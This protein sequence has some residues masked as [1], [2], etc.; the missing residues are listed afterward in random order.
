VPFLTNLLEQAHTIFIDTAPVIY[1][2][3]KKEPYWSLCNLFFDQIDNGQLLGMI[4]PITIAESFYY[5]YKKE[6][7]TLL[8]AFEQRLLNNSRIKV[9]PLTAVIAQR[10]AKLRAEYN[11]GLADALQIA[12]A[13]ETNCDLFLT[14]DQQ[15]QR[16]TGLS[17]LQIVILESL[18]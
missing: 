11:L 13:I 8:R 10:S 1:F 2:V 18:R 12:T 16:V 4:S 6:Q 5:P 17:G 14:N 15:L 9:I 7:Q 3:E